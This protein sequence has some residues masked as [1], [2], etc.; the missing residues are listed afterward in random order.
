[1][2][3]YGLRHLYVQTNTSNNAIFQ[4]GDYQT[5]NVPPKQ[6]VYWPYPETFPVKQLLPTYSVWISS[7]ATDEVISQLGRYGEG[8]NDYARTQQAWHASV[9]AAATATHYAAIEI[10]SPVNCQSNIVID[11]VVVDMAAI[12]QTITVVQSTVHDTNLSNV[13]STANHRIDGPANTVIPSALIHYSTDTTTVPATVQDVF[14]VPA[15]NNQDVFGSQSS[16]IR[17][18]PKLYVGYIG[19][20]VQSTDATKFTTINLD[21]HEEI[22]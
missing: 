5:I 13:A 17:E 7:Y 10:G 20:Y 16:M 2:N 14:I 15:T 3:R 22:A 4:A 12:A 11:R 8:Y 21:W 6:W 19:I 18:I 9:S 1:M